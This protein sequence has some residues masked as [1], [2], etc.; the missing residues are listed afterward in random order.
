MV[1][2]TQIVK[3]ECSVC[4]N[5]PG[6]QQ[7]EKKKTQLDFA[8]RK[9]YFKYTLTGYSVIYCSVC[10]LCSPCCIIIIITIISIMLLCVL[11][12]VVALQSSGVDCQG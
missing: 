6:L 3:N 8:V 7:R 4:D 12:C 2:L 5:G 11:L 1:P 9:K 10:R